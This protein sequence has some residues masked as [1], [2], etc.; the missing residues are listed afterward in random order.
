MPL[1]SQR[2]QIA[3]VEGPTPF[4]IS[5]K[6][7]KG[8]KAVIDT[9]LDV[10]W[11]KQLN[12]NLKITRTA[13]NLILMD[14]NQ[15]W[16][17]PE[18]STQLSLHVEESN[19]AVSETG[20]ISEP[21][22]ASDMFTVEDDG[23]NKNNMSNPGVGHDKMGNNGVT[24]HVSCQ[25]AHMMP[26]IPE[27]KSEVET[28]QRT[29]DHHSSVL[30]GSKQSCPTLSLQS[31]VDSKNGHQFDRENANAPYQ[32]RDQS[33]SR[34]L[35]R[36]Q[37]HVTGRTGQG[38]NSIWESQSRS[39]VCQSLRGSQV[40]RM[41]RVS[42]REERQD[43]PSEVH[44]LCRE[45]PRSGD[46]S[47][48]LQ[49]DQTQDH[50]QE[51]E[52]RSLLEPCER[53]RDGERSQWGRSESQ[54][55]PVPEDGQHGGSSELPLRGEPVLASTPERGGSCTERADFTCQ[56]AQSGTVESECFGVHSS[57]HDMVPDFEFS[58]PDGHHEQ[59][60]KSAVQKLVAQFTAELKTV[61]SPRLHQR[62]LDLLEVMCHSDSELTKQTLHLG[63]KA[64]Q[65][66][67]EQGDLNTTMGRMKLFQDLIKFRP[68]HLWYSLYANHGASGANTMNRNRLNC[69]PRFFMIGWTTCGK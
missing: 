56:G 24:E 27:M 39:E 33:C 6:F 46:R 23:V 22:N 20:K 66:G 68:K 30:S 2:F 63:G 42:V 19:S 21:T 54:H 37:A 29:Q 32:E 64:Q 25:S 36:D 5:S 69:K 41:V 40:D 8:I 49:C 43:C 44:R 35:D 48:P 14:L 47:K 53:G 57:I 55:R 58:T 28:L 45:T 3:V 50:R 26:T 65:F 38:D 1:G 67:L 10:M 18:T 9:D 7:L 4:L 31:T 34:S 16:E 11:S 60:F 17:S 51:G 62:R 13:K 12:R 59:S 52:F 15:L 61:N